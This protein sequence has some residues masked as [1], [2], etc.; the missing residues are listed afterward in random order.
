MNET[1]EF[2]AHHLFCMSVSRM[3][4]IGRGE[5]FDQKI[6]EITQSLQTGKKLRI[7]IAAGTDQLCSVCPDYQNSRCQNEFG[8]ETQVR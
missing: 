2:R 5:E 6:E 3:N 7:K 4:L 1:L 8:D